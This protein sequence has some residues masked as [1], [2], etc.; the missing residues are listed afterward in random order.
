MCDHRTMLIKLHVDSH[1][2]LD[3]ICRALLLY[4]ARLRVG[5]G[6]RRALA[7]HHRLLQLLNLVDRAEVEPALEGLRD[8]DATGASVSTTETESWKE[9]ERTWRRPP[10][11]RNQKTERDTTGVRCD[12]RSTPALADT[13]HHRRRPAASFKAPS[14]RNRLKL[15]TS[16]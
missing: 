15:H 4:R 10:S 14:A 16:T 3:L 7:I 1:D 12:L 9:A 6:L 2:L 11:R 5:R 8:D 13:M